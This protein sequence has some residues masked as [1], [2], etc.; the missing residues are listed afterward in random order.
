MDWGWRRLEFGCRPEWTTRG[1]RGK[2]GSSTKFHIGV[3]D[4]LEL[5]LF[6]AM[7]ID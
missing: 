6:F 7:I 3:L 5:Q 2:L 1:A 4:Y